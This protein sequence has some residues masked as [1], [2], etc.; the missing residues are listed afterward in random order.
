ML[1]TLRLIGLTALLA[2]AF[3]ATSWQ[4]RADDPPRPLE[5]IQKDLD[6]INRSLNSLRGDLGAL[7]RRLA[8]TERNVAELR[9]IVRLLGELARK[10]DA[11]LGNG[12]RVA[13]AFNPDFPPMGVIRLQNRSPYNAT[14][15][16]NGASYPLAPFQTRDVQQMPG[17]FTYEVFA[18]GFGV[19]QPAVSRVLTARETFTIFVYPR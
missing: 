11:Q 5:K 9:D 1:R 15:I 16:L 10:H 8:E 4:A 17:P 2:A 3:G 12:Q 6:E 18:D 14:V 13:R 7:D 19:I